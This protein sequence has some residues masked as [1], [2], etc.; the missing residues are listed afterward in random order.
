MS[1]DGIVI[2]TYLII[3]ACF[4]AF[5]LWDESKDD[6]KIKTDSDLL[7]LMVTCWP[8]WFPMMIAGL[9]AHYLSKGVTK[10]ISKLAEY[11]ASKQG[12]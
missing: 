11:R 2:I 1:N 7:I 3:T 10:L 5:A 4:F 6:G 8:V 12:K 9:T